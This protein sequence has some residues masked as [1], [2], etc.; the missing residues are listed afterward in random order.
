VFSKVSVAGMSFEENILFTHW[1]LSGPAILQISS[2]WRPGQEI[3]IDLLPNFNL[4]NLIKQ[5]RQYGGKRLVSQLLNDYFSRKL[6]DALGK[7]LALDTKIASLSKAD[8]KL[9]VDTI[10]RFKVKPAGDKGYDKAEVMRGGV[11]T[12]EL[13]PKTLMSK[14]VE[15]LYFGG[16]TVDITGWLGGYNFQWAWASGYAIDQDI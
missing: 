14:K 10:H 6:V 15:G 2:Y 4:D 9:I 3:T 8:A 11:S 13:N 12:E 7:F 1:G 16:E 5:E